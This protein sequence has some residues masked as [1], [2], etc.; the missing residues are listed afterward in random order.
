MVAAVD[1]MEAEVAVSTVEASAA[2]TMARM[3]A[4]IAATEEVRAGSAVLGGLAAGM[5]E[6]AEA[7]R[8]ASAALG[9]GLAGARPAAGRDGAQ[10]LAAAS[11]MATGIPLAE[12]GAL[13]HSIQERDSPT[14]V[15]RPTGMVS[16]G[17]ADLADAGSGVVPVSVGDGEVAGA[18]VGDGDSGGAGDGA[19]GDRSGLG[20]PTGIAR[21]GTGIIRQPITIRT[22]I[23]I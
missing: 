5:V 11:P 6:W 7:H 15:E 2:G 16:A 18:A 4:V 19:V 10:A 13:M 3:A 9:G 21:G 14:S 23:S 17:E 20:R 12:R 1:F 8:I 22:V